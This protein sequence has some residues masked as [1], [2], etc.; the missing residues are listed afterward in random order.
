M[1]SLDHVGVFGDK[2]GE[3]AFVL[4]E[5]T[6]DGFEFPDRI[7]KVISGYLSQVGGWHLVCG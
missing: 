6:S 5:H 1:Q 3:L 7:D 4:R 2:V